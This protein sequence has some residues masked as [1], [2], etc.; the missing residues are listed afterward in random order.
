[1]VCSLVGLPDLYTALG[2]TLADSASSLLV[3]QMLLSNQPLLSQFTLIIYFPED[4][5]DSRVNHKCPFQSNY[6]TFSPC[7]F[8]NPSR[9]IKDF[10]SALESVFISTCEL[11]CPVA[12]SVGLGHHSF[13]ALL[14][15]LFNLKAFCLS[16]LN[17]LRAQM[18]CYRCC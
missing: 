7:C 14:Q 10:I 6:F 9:R 5:T 17:S 4:P 15:L 13:I 2:P 11:M 3:S 8:C 12:S 1:M 18:L 16:K